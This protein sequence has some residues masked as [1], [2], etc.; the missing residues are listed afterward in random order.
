MRLPIPVSQVAGRFAVA[1]LHSTHP[2]NTLPLGRVAPQP[3]VVSLA[4]WF[5]GLRRSNAIFH[6]ALL[7][8]SR[9]TNRCHWLIA[10]STAK[11]H[12]KLSGLTLRLH[13]VGSSVAAGPCLT[14]SFPQR[15]STNGNCL[16]LLVVC[17][18]NHTRDLFSTKALVSGE[19][20]LSR[21]PENELLLG[22]TL[23][24]RCTFEFGPSYDASGVSASDVVGDVLVQTLGREPLLGGFLS[25]AWNSYSVYVKVALSIKAR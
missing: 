16:C 22:K 25:F 20:C 4:D 6:K 11:T 8:V 17:V 5:P 15:S 3:T 13:V 2:F 24:G 9:S 18:K 10:E 23:F 12:N 1:V 7:I 14:T 19:E 21:S